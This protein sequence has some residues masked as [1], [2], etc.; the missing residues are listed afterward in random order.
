MQGSFKMLSLYVIPGFAAET[1]YKIWAYK[2]SRMV[3]ASFF[4][5]PNVNHILICML[6]LCSW[7]YRTSIFF[8]VCVIFR[9]ICH[10][11]ILRLKHFSSIFDEKLDDVLF[12][13]TEHMKIRKQLSIIS[14]R[15]RLFII[16]TIA[17]ITISLLSSVVITTTIESNVNFYNAG[18]L[19]VSTFCI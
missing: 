12:L 5:S 10:L 6:D 7:L 15:F 11:Q 3:Y 9:L 2:N 1:G 17:L 16:L 19:A 14:H 13:F 8:L 4:G 18:E